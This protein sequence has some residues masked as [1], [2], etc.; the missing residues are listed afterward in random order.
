[1]VFIVNTSQRSHMLHCFAPNSTE[2]K[3]KAS[4]IINFS[5]KIIDKQMDLTKTKV[6][7]GFINSNLIL[8]F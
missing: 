2:K 6:G 7:I 1:M 8:H 3:L 5:E 4:Q